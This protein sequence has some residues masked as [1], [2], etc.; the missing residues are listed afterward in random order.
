MFTARRSWDRCGA[1]NVR[2]GA[3]VMHAEVAL[4]QL[5]IRVQDTVGL[6]R[7][8]EPPPEPRGSSPSQEL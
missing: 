1:G 7:G 6:T 4:L 3:N 8:A 2:N 5:R